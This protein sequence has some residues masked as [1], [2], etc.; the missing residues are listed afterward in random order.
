MSIKTQIENDFLTAYKAKNVETVSVLRMI[1]SAIKNA[2]INSKSEFSDDEII[3]VLRREVKQREQSVLEFTKGGRAE[4]ADKETKEIDVISQYIPKGLG[5]D[6]L[7]MIIQETISSNGATE[8]KDMG[9]TMA[10]VI[11]KVGSSADGSVISSLVKEALQK[12]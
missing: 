12:K 9:R 8:M 7:K 11:K 4:M 3:K 5:T 10:E 6:E 2:E 1:K